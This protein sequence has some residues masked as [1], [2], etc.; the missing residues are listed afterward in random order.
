M[1]LSDV[2]MPLT[3]VPEK[4]TSRKY[5]LKDYRRELIM[6]EQAGIKRNTIAEICNVSKSTVTRIME[7]A[8]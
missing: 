6:M 8:P 1:N 3:M 5:S 2:Q 4:S 7:K